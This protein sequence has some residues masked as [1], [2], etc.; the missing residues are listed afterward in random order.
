MCDA[1][2]LRLRSCTP[3][4]FW[5]TEF[6]RA[7]F[8]SRGSCLSGCETRRLESWREQ[9]Y[10]HP[11]RHVRKAAHDED[12]GIVAPVRLENA[13]RGPLEDHAAH[14]PRE[15]AD[16]DHRRYGRIINIGSLTSVVALHEVAAYGA[17]KA[18]VAALT[19]Q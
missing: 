7:H 19:N 11:R 6:W 16:A 12:R 2:I 3:T 17:S 10:N 4:Q 13:P 18:G 15:R 1:R 14:R 8:Y 5:L 9:M